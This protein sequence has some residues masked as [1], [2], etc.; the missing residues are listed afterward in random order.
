MMIALG[1]YR[2][3]I[4]LKLI[5]KKIKQGFLFHFLVIILIQISML[6]RKIRILAYKSSSL[7]NDPNILM[8]RHAQS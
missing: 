8:I 1:S 5:N 6:F 2:S 7:K 3:I 4:G